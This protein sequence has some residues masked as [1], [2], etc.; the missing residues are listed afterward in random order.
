MDLHNEEEELTEDEI[1]CEKNIEEISDAIDMD[2]ED[3]NFFKLVDECRETG[4]EPYEIKDKVEGNIRYNIKQ[5]VEQGKENAYS[6]FLKVLEAF[7]MPL[8]F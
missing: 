3:F 2:K 5:D 4:M 1:L 6:S 7:G 8:D